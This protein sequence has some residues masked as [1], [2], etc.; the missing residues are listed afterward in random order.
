[1]TGRP[2]REA[3]LVFLCATAAAA[4]LYH[5]SFVIPFVAQT[6]HFFVAVV[7]LLAPALVARRRGEELADYGFT[8]KPF[9][10]S[11]LYGLT[12]LAVVFPLFILGYVLFYQVVCGGGSA[13][14]LWRL[15]PPG[16]CRQFLGWA[17]LAHFRLPREPFD[18]IAGQ[19]V[20]VALPEELFFRGYLLKRLEEAFPPRRRLL[21]GGVGVALLLSA[22]L[23]ALGHVLV[24]L[25][26]RRL[27][28]FFPGLLF[29]WMR[30]A[31]GSI[32]A[33]TLAHASSNVF[34]ECLNRT[35]FR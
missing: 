34:I 18:F 13:G 26:P 20:V 6:L 14:P 24:D 22:L 7:F 15:A 9:G 32:L 28:V 16:F 4:A 12:P 2:L 5:L 31:T 23:F 17:G 25:D 19:L 27:A 21:G 11:L 10:R 8:S 30:S 33:G 3:L 29:G 1:M 35:F